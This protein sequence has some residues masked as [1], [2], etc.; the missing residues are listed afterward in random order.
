MTAKKILIINA[1]WEQEDLIR[2]A[3]SMGLY[4]IA[5]DAN[6]H[7]PALKLADEIAIFEPRD[8]MG[9]LNFAKSKNV[10]G[11]IA[12]QCDYSHYTATLIADVL[13][14][15]STGLEA[16]QNATNKK[17]LRQ[18]CQQENILQPEFY[19]CKS[20]AE[21]VKASTNISFPVIV[22]PVDNRG[23]FGIT[24]VDSINELKQAFY[25]AIANS[26]SRECLVEKFI[27]GT[28]IT[29]DGFTYSDGI[30]KSLA[31]ASKKMLEE[32]NTVAME[33]YYPAKC[34]EDIIIKLKENHDKVVKALGVKMG[35]T[36]GEYKLTEENEIYLIEC[37]NRGG[38][39]YTSSRI[40]TSVSGEDISKL[41]ILSAIGEKTTPILNT[42]KSACVLSFFKFRSG[43]IEK[44]HNKNEIINDKD[45]LAFRLSVA[46]GDIVKQIEGDASRHGFII[47]KGNDLESVLLKIEDLKYKL[48]VEYD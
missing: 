33:I 18:A 25:L 21:A 48:V 2:T 16:V 42:N 12:D 8:I 35:C 39:V 3:K 11:V 14:L 15:P 1:G 45:V 19:P 4:V 47:V 43:T 36:H 31:V 10:S 13:N 26:H 7:A 20:Y 40:V 24:R 5:I 29:V 30:H 17:W 46:E 37:A 41:L 23:N 32:K 9:I 44:I 38:G 27:E 34:S 28:M 22:K 6:I